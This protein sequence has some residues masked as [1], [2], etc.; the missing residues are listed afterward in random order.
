LIFQT[1]D[2]Y[3]AHLGVYDEEDHD[4]RWTGLARGTASANMLEALPTLVHI[5]HLATRTT[6]SA[7]PTRKSKKAK[8]PPM[9]YAMTEA[10]VPISL[11]LTFSE[12]ECRD[13]IIAAYPRLSKAIVI[14]PE[15]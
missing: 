10:T 5:A 14:D 6:F 15:R 12:G 13:D 7:R 1:V 3:C 9:D 4:E 8:G 2:H 11:R